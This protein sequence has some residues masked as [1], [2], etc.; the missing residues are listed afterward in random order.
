MHSHRTPLDVVSV[1]R[2]PRQ[3]ASKKRR[4]LIRLLSTVMVALGFLG[5]FAPGAAASLA[6]PRAIIGGTAITSGTVKRR[7]HNWA[8]YVVKD[9][10][11]FR[12]VKGSWVQPSITCNLPD[13]TAASFW[14]GLGGVRSNTRGLEQIGTA[15]ECD[16]EGRF[17]YSSWY[18]LWPA[19]PVRLRFPVLPGDRFAASVSVRGQ[20]VSLEINNLTTG[21]TFARALSMRSP[22]TSS[23]EWIAESPATGIC[24]AVHSYCRIFPLADFGTVN[25]YNAMAVTSAGER[26][27]ISDTDFSAFDIHLLDEGGSLIKKPGRPLVHGSPGKAT[28]SVLTTEGRSFAVTW[29]QAPS[30]VPKVRHSR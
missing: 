21:A 16:A 18:E 14:V 15:E 17:R 30:L 11:P 25:F 5:I 4:F 13:L 7:S 8:G 12:R 29:Q 20:E 22:D 3:N 24:W 28:P 19:P 10:S 6:A 9:H 1:I 27:S 23:A 2:L 26:G